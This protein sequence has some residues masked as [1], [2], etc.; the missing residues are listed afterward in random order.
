MPRCY[1]A[2]SNPTRPLG[3][4]SVHTSPAISDAHTHSFGSLMR[5]DRQSP[6]YSI[7]GGY[8]VLTDI[9]RAL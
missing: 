8:G 3:P 4:V 1:N 9:Q 6:R 7:F 2:R 5:T